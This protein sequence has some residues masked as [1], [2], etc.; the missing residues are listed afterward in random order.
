M[1]SVCMLVLFVFNY[2]SVAGKVDSL[3]CVTF[4]DK[5]ND[6]RSKIAD[7]YLRLAEIS[8]ESGLRCS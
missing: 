2:Y 8:N 6:H 5:D 7:C 3:N 4:S 1:T